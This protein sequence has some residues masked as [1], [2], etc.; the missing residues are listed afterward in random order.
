MPAIYHLRDLA[1]AGGL[2]SYGASLT[3]AY[4]LAGIYAGPHSQRR[5]A[6][7]STGPAV[8]QV[9]LGHQSQDRQGRRQVV[10]LLCAAVVGRVAAI[11]NLSPSGRGP[12][13]KACGEENLWR[14]A[15]LITVRF[16]S[17]PSSR[18]RI[19]DH[20]VRVGP[21]AVAITRAAIRGC[22]GDR[23]S[24]AVGRGRPPDI[25]RRCR[26]VGGGRCPDIRRP[27]GSASNSSSSN[28][29]SCCRAPVFA[30]MDSSA[31]S[32]NARCRKG[33]SD[34]GFGRVQREF[35]R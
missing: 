6:G 15:K 33:A 23:R 13:T 2:M 18:D 19:D 26:R 35:C 4:R 1:V 9:R 8:H 20:R 34:P 27:S 32:S 21:W 5:K 24:G 3:D 29:S 14:P 22:C 7:R 30:P 10:T 16:R 17:A 31:D 25:R 28:R 12:R 11:G